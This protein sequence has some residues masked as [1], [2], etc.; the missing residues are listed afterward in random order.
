MHAN[1]AGI[2]ALNCCCREVEALP[3]EDGKAMKKAVV[4][5]LMSFM[6]TFTSRPNLTSRLSSLW[7]ENQAQ[8]NLSKQDI[9]TEINKQLSE[10]NFCS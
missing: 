3:D 9:A 6:D 1:L 7:T 4:D 5:H 10:G 8:L 2:K